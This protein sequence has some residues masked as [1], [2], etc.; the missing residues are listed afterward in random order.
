[1]ATTRRDF[2]KVAS[3]TGLALGLRLDAG[4]G[5]PAALAPNAWIRVGRDGRVRVTVGKSEM[6]QGVRTAL[7][8]IVADELGVDWER[9]DLA[10]AEPGPDFRHLGTGGSMSIQASWM[11]LRRAA[12]AAREMLVQAAAQAW[13]VAPATCRV[14]RGEVLH[15]PT[16]R[17][18]GFGR[19]VQAAA[20]LPVPREPRLAETRTLIGRPTRR[21]DGPRIVDGRA[22]YGLDVALPGMRHA[23]V[24]R[25]PVPGGKAL[26]WD[27]A[28]VRALPG[29]QA[30]IPIDSGVA[31]VADGT[32]AALAAAAALRAT[33]D[34]GPHA[35]FS[36]EAFRAVLADRV[37]RPGVP[38]RRAGDADAALARAARRLTAEYE[39]P[40]QAHATLEPPN[41]VA[42]VKAGGCDLWT[43]TQSPNEVQARAAKLLGV[44]PARVRVR[45]PLLGGG[46]GRRLSSEF[47][48]EAVQVSRAAGGPI[49]LVW[50]REDD[51][52]H[53]R[54]HPMSLHRLEAALDGGGLQAWAHRIAAP[55]ILLS[56]MEGRRGDG[57]V[58]AETNGAADLPYR[59]PHIRVDY[60]EA[61]CHLPLGWW[62]AI[63]AMPNVFARECF[64]DECAAALGRDPLAL[65]RELLAG[66]ET[67]DVG[68][69]RVDL[70]RLRGVLD[71]AAARAGWASP[72][73]PGRAR[74]L[75]CSAYDAHTYCALVA[76]VATDGAG[77]KVARIVAAVDC[78]IV[79]NPL[80]LAG[81]VESGVLWGLSA[82]RTAITFKAGQV[83]QTSLSDL[84][85]AQMAD[86]PAIEV[87]LVPSQ[88][89]PTGIGEPPVPLVIPAVLN[90]VHALTG[91]RIRRLPLS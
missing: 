85:I 91:T 52:R 71:L 67:R 26:R 53:D 18:T 61:P 31:V 20:R 68:G 28:A 48:L 19:L 83:E 58:S 22:V 1:M 13:G 43:G 34:P 25:C 21:V 64:L 69:E 8:M 51:L 76:E 84:P 15:P 23:A 17:R 59:I 6:G 82:L 40:W 14:E 73:P 87:H 56:W 89:P 60:A 10:Q 32:H 4:E 44:D 80:G 72:P 45:V 65:R 50:S 5:A 37:A 24:A 75:A 57:L 7:P 47:A 33:W 88:A 41:C 11:P 78:G 74:G 55:S 63:E 79:V 2:L 54:F 38:A 36:S 30:V 77:W 27:E 35:G 49:Q 9:V 12:A 70:G 16:G 46:F 39:F 66:A 81:N 86:A 29:V 3:V 90:A 42:H 62:R